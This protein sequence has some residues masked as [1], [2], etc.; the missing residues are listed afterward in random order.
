M[1]IRP[2]FISNSSTTSFII[3]GIQP[4]EK[5]LK[6]LTKDA[7]AKFKKEW[8]KNNSEYDAQQAEEAQS[9]GDSYT[10]DEAD[11]DDIWE[12]FLYEYEG[13]SGL[14]LHKSDC[15]DNIIYIGEVN[16]VDYA[17]EFDVSYFAKTAK[18]VAKALGVP[19]SKIKV[20]V[21]YSAQM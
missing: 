11:D 16:A 21:D 15:G 20:Y 7:F 3:V 6:E 12:E 18:K 19:E 17:E 4:S 13:P 2:G 9:K 14:S 1:K 5:Q 8:L 10:P